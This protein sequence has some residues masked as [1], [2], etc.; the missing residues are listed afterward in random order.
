[1]N[2][3][4]NFVFISDYLL[5]EDV[6]TAPALEDGQD[7][8]HCTAVGS[9]CPWLREATMGGGRA[10]CTLNRVADLPPPWVVGPLSRGSTE[11]MNVFKALAFLHQ[12]CLH[13]LL[14]QVVCYHVNI[15]LLPAGPWPQPVGQPG[16]EGQPAGQQVTDVRV[17]LLDTDEEVRM[18]FNLLLSTFPFSSNWPTGLI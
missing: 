8:G 16:P 2:S 10:W 11:S 3:K 5:V 12:L 18:L 13:S 15:N 1:M 7:A 4:C 17:N 14:Y 6:V 9:E